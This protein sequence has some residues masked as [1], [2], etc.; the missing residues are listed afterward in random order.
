MLTVSLAKTMDYTCRIWSKKTPVTDDAEWL[1]LGTYKYELTTATKSRL[2]ALPS[3]LRTSMAY[4]NNPSY[5]SF[6]TDQEALAWAYASS[7]AASHPQYGYS[8]NPANGAHYSSQSG[9]SHSAPIQ[10]VI[11]P[12]EANND[13]GE[14]SGQDDLEGGRKRYE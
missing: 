9:G 3:T 2:I 12:A 5:A 14:G 4:Y 11:E 8:T 13:S 10:I 7:Q 1:A 6:A